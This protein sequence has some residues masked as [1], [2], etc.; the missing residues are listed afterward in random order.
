MKS[1]VFELGLLAFFVSAV[2]FGSQGASLFDMITQAFIVFIGI[3]LA[4]AMVLSMISPRP[5]TREVD[6]GENL[7]DGQPAKRRTPAA[8]AKA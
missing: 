1:I 6:P 7:G 3:E 8:P 4:A 5:R 2:V